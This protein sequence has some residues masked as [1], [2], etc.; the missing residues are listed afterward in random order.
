MTSF[1][2]VIPPGKAGNVT[3]KLDT[4]KLHGSVGRGITVRTDDPGSPS[5]FLTVRAE[6]V[7]GVTILPDEVLHVNNGSSGGTGGSVVITRGSGES[8]TLAIGNLRASVPWLTA[9][10]E[11][12]TQLRPGGDGLPAARPGDW[13]IQVTPAAG[14]PYG[15]QR[16]ELSFST[17]LP[18][19]SEVVL[20]VLVFL[21]PPVRLSMERLT[22]PKS[23]AGEAEPQTVLLTVRPGLDPAALEIEARPASLQ[24]RLEPSGPRGFKL[25]VSWQGAGEPHGEILFRVGAESF[26]LPV[27]SSDGSS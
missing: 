14:T 4:T 3:A 20:P 15:R 7:G 25:Y 11:P 6:I 17:G 8:G 27:Y 10:A 19:Q 21:E 2:E 18:R 13:V 12:V 22:L 5:L 26:S 24:A 1:D 16:A 23:G 9:T